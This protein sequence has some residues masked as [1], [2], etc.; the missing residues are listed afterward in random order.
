MRRILVVEIL[1]D[2]NLLSSVGMTSSS[3]DIFFSFTSYFSMED[4]VP[5][6]LLKPA[7]MKMVLSSKIHA[8]HCDLCTESWTDSLLCQTFV[9]TL[10]YSQ[11]FSWIF[12]SMSYPP[13]V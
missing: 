6:S 7:K 11:D 5:L 2:V 4:R 1:M 3:I 13:N 8:E 10:K 12:S 9:E